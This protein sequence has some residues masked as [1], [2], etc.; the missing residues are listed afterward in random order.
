MKKVKK[1]SIINLY[2]LIIL[3]VECIW[4]LENPNEHIGPENGTTPVTGSTVPVGEGIPP[5]PGQPGKP[6]PNKEALN[7]NDI[8]DGIIV[9]KTLF[10]G[11]HAEADSTFKAVGTGGFRK[12]D[13]SN[14]LTRGGG[15]WCSEHDLMNDRIVK[16]TATL[17]T[18]LVLRGV[19]IYWQYSPS[20]VSIWVSKD[21]DEQFFQVLP[22]QSC[23]NVGE[24]QELVFPKKIR[25]KYVQIR[26]KGQVNGYFGITFVQFIGEE[27]PVFRI[28]SGITS[29]E[30]MCLQVDTT[31]EVVLE[32]CITA[33]SKFEFKD[34]WRYNNKR[35]VYNPISKLCLT[36][37]NN[38]ETEGGTLRMLP[39]KNEKGE[40]YTDGRNSWTFTSNNQIKM[41]RPGNLCLSQKGSSAGMA[42][43]A[44]NKI[45]KSNYSILN[46]E[47]NA[48]ERALDGN[49]KSYWMSRKFKLEEGRTVDFIIDLQESYKLQTIKIDW[50][51]PALSYNIYTKNEEDWELAKNVG[52]N[53]LKSTIDYL[54]DKQAQYIKIEMMK[55]N[56]EYSD[57]SGYVQYGIGNV[58]VYTNKLKTIVESCETARHSKDA[59]DKYF[60]ESVHQVD[61]KNI[62]PIKRAE[63]KIE[64][65]VKTI[66]GKLAEIEKLNA[67]ISKCKNRHESYY[68]KVE[69]MKRVYKT[70]LEKL[71]QVDLH[72]TPIKTAEWEKR[73]FT[74][75]IQIKNLGENKPSG[76]YDITPVCGSGKVRVYCDMY[77]GSSYYVTTMEEGH[78]VGLS[79]VM[80][81]CAK[82]GLHPLHIQHEKQV[83]SL[84]I[85]LKTM[86][87]PPGS[88]F[89]IAVKVGQTL[90]SLDLK[91]DVSKYVSV[92]DLEKGNVLG[93]T[94]E[95][96]ELYDGRDKDMSGV[97][98]STN[99]SSV[100]LPE[101]VPGVGCGT[102]ITDEMSFPKKPGSKFKIRCPQNC[103]ETND[104]YEVEGGKDGL[105][106]F[107]SSLCLAA[108]HAGE[109]DDKAALQVEIFSSP[110][111]L[112]GFY[113]NGINSASVSTTLG[114]FA[115]TVKRVESN[116]KF[117][118]GKK[119]VRDFIRHKKEKENNN[120]TAGRDKSV[121]QNR[122]AIEKKQQNNEPMKTK[123]E[124]E[125]ND[126]SQNNNKTDQQQQEQEEEDDDG[127]DSYREFEGKL[128]RVPPVVEVNEPK[129]RKK[130]NM[131]PNEMS[132][133]QAIHSLI[134]HIYAQNTK[135]SPIF[136]DLF[137]DHTGL[138]LANTRDLI[139]K[140]DLKKLP[141]QSMFVNL[142]HRVEHMGSSIQLI[143]SQISYRRQMVMQ[144]IEKL[145]KEKSLYSS[146]ESFSLLKTKQE[147]LFINF[148]VE[149][150]SGTKGSPTWVMS[151]LNVKNS[152]EL[153]VSQ[154]SQVIPPN[155]TI[156][157]SY[158]VLKNRKFF[159]FIFSTSI[160]AGSQGSLGVAFRIVDMN[161]YYL[162]QLKQSNGGFKRLIRVIDGDPYELARV[163]D[164]GF[165]E[166]VWYHVRVETRQSRL[167][168]SVV[169]GEDEIFETP[170]A[171]IDV[172][173]STHASGTVALYTGKVSYAHFKR[174]NVEALPCLRY[175]SPPLPPDPPFCSIFR[176][177]YLSN[178]SNNWAVYNAKG[179]W[180]FDKELMGEERVIVNSMKLGAQEDTEPTIAVLKNHKSC[181]YGIF[182]A[183]VLTQCDFG[184]AGLVFRFHNAG[185]FMM[186]ELSPKYAALKQMHKGVLETVTETN[187]KGL[188][189][190]VWTTFSVTFNDDTMT[191][192][193]GSPDNSDLLFLNIRASHELKQ[194][195]S[196]GLASVNCTGVAFTNVSL[197]PIYK[198]S[199]GS[200]G[201]EKHS[202]EEQRGIRCLSVD[203]KAECEKMEPQSLEACEA[204]FCSHCCQLNYNVKEA[205]AVCEEQ[206]ARQDEKV[207]L[208]ERYLDQLW[209]NCS[210]TKFI[211]KAECKDRDC[212]TNVCGMCCESSKPQESISREL[213]G[214][215]KSKC[216]NM[217][218]YI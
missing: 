84:A 143:A 163:E 149:T 102:R 60:L 133:G 178:F 187:L 23:E 212:K 180:K 206:C 107:N 183:S 196:V 128:E 19:K 77:T 13:A 111:E 170:K 153:T 148:M 130:T 141:G 4:Y 34:V 145:M 175:D 85:M 48:A 104:N 162:L 195:G 9:N 97:I 33:I 18:S 113:Q 168:I 54:N 131:M 204:N 93:V 8:Q 58:A 103:H 214:I 47:E 177:D 5:I 199:E 154:M 136:L 74:D 41:R 207:A 169:Q 119:A 49:A 6:P 1:Y 134:E 43:V 105:Y 116:C 35:Q 87:V 12:Y 39:C 124:Q 42:N 99:Y 192:A 164:G 62:L 176:E 191:V 109:Y 36:L 161:N 25:A 121:Q 146:F 182:T 91:V 155:N 16:W 86:E 200:M 197:K 31:G 139:K 112:D 152:T 69:Q 57:E 52:A 32:S 218:K 95:G 171:V 63:E 205:Q 166:E 44:L 2:L 126:E 66:E 3:K 27:N 159:D 53:T 158:L 117:K 96:V 167:M 101:E 150:T 186:L 88:L 198:S 115:F 71:S 15:Y 17:K 78:R 210:S 194:G 160:Y 135:G 70:S 64:D 29:V 65:M 110:E 147:S 144:K 181:T 193:M 215:A 81:E 188:P 28:Q 67:K 174:F 213:N 209:Y 216:K 165:I 56:P 26:M 108:I 21:D 137:R 184:A 189:L 94:Q 138:V 122:E 173:D 190:N 125:N 55:I 157:G 80:D 106:S 38:I 151:E 140:A 127:T 76:F 37:E 120:Q 40:D 79:D 100:K 72:V 83:D 208:V 46:K 129:R 142:D 11:V 59:R 51:Y 45:A 98:C 20:Y 90:R 202:E 201:V 114:D 172:I 82:Y 24:E 203:R 14:A 22:F 217:C 50:H 61:M 211:D 30:D 179:D 68:N 92:E 75:C 89:P 132:T 7:S 10:G 123:N 156:A 118:R 73:E 185:E